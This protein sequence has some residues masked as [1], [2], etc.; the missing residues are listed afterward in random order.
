MNRNK[1]EGSTPVDEYGSRL[2]NAEDIDSADRSFLE[3]GLSSAVRVLNAS[4][5]A[6]YPSCA[7]WTGDLFLLLYISLN[8]FAN[9]VPCKCLRHCVLHK[10]VL[11]LTKTDDR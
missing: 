7:E 8:L 11:I 2:L 5:T 4:S 9:V 6:D 10:I 3:Y 1:L